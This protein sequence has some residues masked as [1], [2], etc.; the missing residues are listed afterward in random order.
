MTIETRLRLAAGTV[1]LL[2]LVSL[3]HTSNLLEDHPISWQAPLF[4]AL[5]VFLWNV[6]L[7]LWDSTKSR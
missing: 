7:A 6:G 3:V 4:L 1:W 5:T 2:T